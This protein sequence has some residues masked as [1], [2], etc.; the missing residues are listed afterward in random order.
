MPKIAHIDFSHAAP[1]AKGNADKLTKVATD[2]TERAADAARESV[3]VANG[4]A[5]AVGG[6]QYETL[7]QS[8]KDATKL[9]E[10]FMKLLVEQ[11]RHNLQLATAVAKAQ[12]DF[13]RGSF[14]RMSQLN[15]RYREVM[16]GA[17]NSKLRSAGTQGQKTT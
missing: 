14:K 2:A 1:A 5:D 13:V 10:L 4:A 12:G 3:R 6:M 17:M 16:Q 7:R 9:G 15:G 11:A 8:S